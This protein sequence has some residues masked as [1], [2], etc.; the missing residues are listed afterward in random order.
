MSKQTQCT[1]VQTRAWLSASAYI[2][3]FSSSD[4]FRKNI[5]KP[6]FVVFTT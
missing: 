6:R 3:R 5:P 4:E 2:Q 1:F